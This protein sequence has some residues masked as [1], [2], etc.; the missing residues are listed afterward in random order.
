MGRPCETHRL[1]RLR[2]EGGMNRYLHVLDAEPSL[3]HG[4]LVLAQLR[5]KEVLTVIEL[6]RALGGGWN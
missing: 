5:H 2:Y 6:Y 4:E 3:F 1:S